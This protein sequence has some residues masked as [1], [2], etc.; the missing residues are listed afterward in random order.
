M[1]LQG[2]LKKRLLGNEKRKGTTSVVTKTPTREP[3][4]LQQVSKSA[5]QQVSDPTPSVA[6]KSALNGR[7]FKA[8]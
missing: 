8:C 5:S 7:N 4:L 1:Q 3:L 6:Q 2:L